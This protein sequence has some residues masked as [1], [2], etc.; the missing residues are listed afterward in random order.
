MAHPGIRFLFETP[1]K[2][3]L[4]KVSEE[5]NRQRNEKFPNQEK[6]DIAE[7]LL[8]FLNRILPRLKP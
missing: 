3:L 8:E 2:R 5:S 1:G 6:F 4:E 7:S